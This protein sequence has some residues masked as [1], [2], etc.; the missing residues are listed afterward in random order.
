MRG[1]AGEIPGVVTASVHIS[2]ITPVLNEAERI[3]PCLNRLRAWRRAGHELIVVDGGSS[4]GSAALARPLADQVLEAPPCRALQLRAGSA[5]ASGA[6]L[7]F[8][9]VDTELPADAM[10]RLEEQARMAPCWGHFD[11][12]LSGAHG[13]LRILER[14]IN[15]RSRLTGVATGDQAIFVSRA[16][17]LECGGFP[18]IALME[19]VAFCKMLRRRRRPLCL[20]PPV[21][22]SSRR[23]EQRGILRTVLLM[24]WLRFAFFLGVRP[25]HLAR[26][27]R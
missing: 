8:L 27:Y 26:F 11:V 1:G 9:H 5:A 22:T 23:W 4:D 21:I 24:W 20:S 17:Y 25:E 12:R 10:E 16:L 6:L 19:D 14:C 7:L 18:P 15:W 13:L 3:A 2:I